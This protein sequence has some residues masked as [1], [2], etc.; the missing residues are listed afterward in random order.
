[1]T[2]SIPQNAAPQ[3][4]PQPFG[5][6]SKESLMGAPLPM[7]P[8][9]TSEALADLKKRTA[10]IDAYKR[11][12]AVDQH[13]DS[14]FSAIA[15]LGGLNKQEV[16]SSWGVDPA[17]IK[18]VKSIFGKP[19]LRTNGG[20][21]IDGMAELLQQYGYL[22]QRDLHEFEAKFD[23]ELRGKPVLTIQGH[24]QA[25]QQ[26]AAQAEEDQKA[27]SL[28]LT[29]A[30]LVVDGYEALN[31]PEK[32]QAQTIID[33]GGMFG[34]SCLFRDRAGLTEAFNCKRQTNSCGSFCSW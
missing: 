19:L 2:A 9:G 4:P 21:S 33:A 15:K 32:E 3:A 22:D 25:A 5:V 26:T 16:V 27:E 13:R 29:H 6:P 14:L 34:S 30:E 18:K 7:V 31:E 23:Q 8:T 28:G 20:M 11:R 12:N 17:D 10:Q 1:M 24:E